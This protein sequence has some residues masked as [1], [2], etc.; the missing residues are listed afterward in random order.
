M[1]KTNEKIGL[2]IVVL[3]LVVF[4]WYLKNK[5]A[6]QNT[7]TAIVPTTS[8][9][10]TTQNDINNLFKPPPA[11]IQK[12][13]TA[14]PN[15][16][17]VIVYVDCDG[18][19]RK[20]T[21]FDG[22]V[23]LSLREN[24][25]L[26]YDVPYDFTK[27]IKI[28]PT[29]SV[30][31]KYDPSIILPKELHDQGFYEGQVVTSDFYKAIVAYNEKQVDILNQRQL[32]AMKDVGGYNYITE[33]LNVDS[34]TSIVAQIEQ[35][36]QNG[37]VF[38]PKGDI[39]LLSGT[40]DF[41]FVISAVDAGLVSN[42]LMGNLQSLGLQSNTITQTDVN[43]LNKAMDDAQN[44]A[45]TSLSNADLYQICMANANTSLQQDY[46]KNTAMSADAR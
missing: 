19:P 5:K 22:S 28:Y 11:C 32:K 13:F 6:S 20:T 34:G 41:Q 39:A 40:K 1:E 7:T 36:I 33:G 3:L 45:N 30:T 26:Y 31:L 44:N 9:N 35:G 16:S 2:G 23:T 46:C 27:S 37:S 10:T 43:N 12:T 4:Y 21:L 29:G 17:R 8:Q 42:D 38:T 14:I 15:N 18:N 25:E 24:S